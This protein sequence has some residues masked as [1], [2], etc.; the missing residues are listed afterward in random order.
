MYAHCAFITTIKVDSCGCVARET[1]AYTN[2][3]IISKPKFFQ[4]CLLQNTKLHFTYEDP[5]LLYLIIICRS[6]E[7]HFIEHCGYLSFVRGNR[8]AVSVP[9]AGVWIN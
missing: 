6:N 3:F 5:P 8:P 4:G 2:P 7:I 9:K 1:L